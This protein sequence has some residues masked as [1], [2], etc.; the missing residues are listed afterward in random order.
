MAAA[1]IFLKIESKQVKGE[2]VDDTHKDELELMSWS[3]GVANTGST[4]SGKGSGQG[5]AAIQD[6][7]FTMAMDKAAPVLF[8]G[9]VQGT[10]Y[11]KATLVQRRAGGDA[12]VE[13]VKLTMENV[14]VSSVQ[15]GSAGQ[16]A[17]V[18][19]SLNFGKFKLEYTPQTDKGGKGEKTEFGYDIPASKTA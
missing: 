1:D 18:S 4:H 14:L 2:S 13:F 16:E 19:I 7:S 15:I 17:S 8:G 6:A 10:H 9:C 11:G 5:K 12:S 3:W